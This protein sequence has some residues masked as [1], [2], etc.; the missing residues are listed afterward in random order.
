[1]AGEVFSG[2]G[3]SRDVDGEGSGIG[4]WVA[5]NMWYV[6]TEARMKRQESG[7][8]GRPRR[9]VRFGSEKAWSCQYRAKRGK[10]G[11]GGE[12]LTLE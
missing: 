3:S 9:R 11:T 7:M 8:T 5:R 4:R 1:M 10:Q 6:W 12:S 2:K